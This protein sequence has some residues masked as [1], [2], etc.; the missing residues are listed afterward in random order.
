MKNYQKQGMLKRISIAMTIPLAVAFI[1]SA[2]SLCSSISQAAPNC[3]QALPVQ[4]SALAP[5]DSVFVLAD[6]MPLYPGGD[7]ALLKFIA[8][9]SKYPE[10]CMKNHVTGK[11]ILKFVVNKDCTVSDISVLQ[12]VNPLLDAEAIRVVKLLPRFEKPAKIKG[13]AV[14]VYYM[15]PI[16]FSLK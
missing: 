11:V 12:S 6:E 10:Q 14:A 1:F 5:G 4:S 13:K 8:D 3:S 9:S 7:A 15:V 16:T 2:P